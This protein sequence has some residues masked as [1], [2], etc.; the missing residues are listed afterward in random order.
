MR[1]RAPN[2]IFRL[3]TMTSTCPTALRVTRWCIVFSL[4]AAAGVTQAQVRATPPPDSG[5]LLQEVPK[6]RN[7]APSSS[8]G[9]TVE[10]QN[11]NNA[12]NSTKFSVRTIEITGNTELPTD[13]LHA[14]VA[15]GEGKDLTLSDL[16]ELAE[17]ISDAYHKHGYPLATAY[18]PAQTIKN[19]IVRIDVAEARY[20]KVVLNNQSSVSNRVLNATLSPLQPGQPVT[21]FT[22]ERSLLLLNDIPGATAN[23]TLRP[24]D[25]VG[26]SDLVVDVTPQPR[27]TGELGLDNFGNEYTDPVRASGAFSINGLLHQGDLLDLDAVTSGNGMRYG[28]AGYRYL[29]TGQ[30][31]T[32]GAYVSGLDYTLKGNLSDLDAHGNAQVGSVVLAQ[33]LIRNTRGNLYLQLEFDHRRLNDDIDVIGLET[34][35]HTN[36]WTLTLA[37]D[38]VDST[39]VSNLR[40]ATTYG[41]LYPDN[42]QTEFIDDIGARTAGSFTKYVLS[43]SRLQQLNP[44]N[45]FYFG[46][47]AQGANKNL[48]T[49]EQFYLGGPDS[50]RGYDVGVLAGAEGNLATIEFRH[51]ATFGFIPGRWQF[52]VFV[53]S[54]RVQPYKDAIFP[55]P[56][57]A[58]LNSAGLGVHWSGPNSWL[59]NASIANPVGN[60]PELLGANA[61]THAHFWVEVRKGFY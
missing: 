40:I 36:N 4:A 8:L 14:L 60:T 42:L 6:P 46:F 39:G 45:A 10:Q 41:H 52:A 56:N 26:T 7:Q 48:D 53:D 38:Q 50:V 57:S 12:D 9:L 24:G 27:Y 13:M 58:R 17:R 29:L 44:T 5:Q 30:G 19:G 2:D 3:L 22:L 1:C 11:Q 16:N 37:G 25:Q 35:R 61:S 28:R 18:V 54:G 43:L 59:I 55:G 31:T 21:G 20:G 51:D 23:S 32:L 49:S 47:S 15:S 34:R 33:P